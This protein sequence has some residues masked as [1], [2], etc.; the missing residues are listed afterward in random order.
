MKVFLSF[1]EKNFIEHTYFYFI[2]PLGHSSSSLLRM[3]VSALT[4]NLLVMATRLHEA[5]STS[6]GLRSFSF[7]LE[8]LSKDFLALYY[9]LSVVA[10]FILPTQRGEN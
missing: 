1:S 8:R 7:E 9:T 6:L 4:V 10:A 5:I 3:L 2:I